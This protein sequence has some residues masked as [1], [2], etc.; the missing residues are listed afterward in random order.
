MTF[1]CARVYN[2]VNIQRLLFFQSSL[3]VRNNTYSSY[4]GS[5]PCLNMQRHN[6]LYY[7]TDDSGHFA[8][9]WQFANDRYFTRLPV[10]FV[11]RVGRIFPYEVDAR[12]FFQLQKLSRHLT[13]LS[14]WQ[15]N[16]WLKNFR[17]VSF[18]NQETRDSVPYHHCVWTGSETH[19]E[20]HSMVKR[21]KSPCLTN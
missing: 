18:K 16:G 4:F 11:Y 3:A 7:V 14:S 10:L 6:P 21:V 19:S 5:E 13:S 2:F 20:Y 12:T 9:V 8:Y 15:W 1:W 17:L